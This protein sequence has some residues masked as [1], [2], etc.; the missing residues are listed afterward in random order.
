MAYR[1]GTVGQ[2]L[3][4][5]SA[6]LLPVAGIDRGGVLHVAGP[7]VMTGYLRATNPGV[8]EPP[9]SEA[10]EGWYDTGDIVEFD[11]NNFVRIV[12]RVKRFAKVAG[13]MVSLET[14]EKLAFHASPAK[15]HASSTQPD[16]AR[17]ETIIL[18]TTDRDL[19]RDHL[20]NAAKEGGWPE[21]AIPRTI[22]PVDTL[23]LLGT[24]KVDYVTLKTWAEKA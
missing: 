14:V 11:E 22:I 6:K 23:P 1:T 5:I 17:G 20:Q 21:I 2:L 10:G 18:Y 15:L 4:G 24:G 12:G 19:T 7:N 16:P 8:L 9:S 3:P 13:E